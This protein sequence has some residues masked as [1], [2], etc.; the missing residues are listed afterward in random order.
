VFKNYCPNCKKWG[1][2]RFD[3]GKAN[4][5]ITSSTYGVHYKPGVP[6]HEVT[7]IYCDSDYCGVTG[8]EKSHGHISRLK[9][10]KKPVKS[11]KT[12]FNKLVKGKL[13]HSTKTVTVKT[14]QNVNKQN[15]RKVKASGIN[16]KVKKQA[17]AIVKNKKG[18]NAARAITSWI[19]NHIVY[20]G[21]P[22]FERSPATVL[23]KGSGNCC[24]VTR[25]LLQML[26]VAGCT[27][28]F[29]MEYV[30]VTGHVYAR[31]TTEKTGKTRPV[32]CASDYSGAWGYICRNYRGLHEYKTQYPKLPF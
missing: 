23:S 19:D 26:D 4:K 27:E 25:L 18:Y 22:N 20:A 17:L 12:E 3:G 28:Y 5:C 21:Y 13:L 29:K 11:S 16:D 10:V 32:D 1:G 24:D 6:E 8:L 15:D 7:C 14:K 30:H 2:L 31:L 9:T